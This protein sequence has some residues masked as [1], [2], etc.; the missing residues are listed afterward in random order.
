MKLLRDIILFVKAWRIAAV[1][2]VDEKI[3]KYRPEAR[4]L[5]VYSQVRAELMAG[6]RDL[7]QLTASMIHAAIALAYRFRRKAAISS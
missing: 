6:G 5:I 2:I 7:E 4:H 3:A 1:K